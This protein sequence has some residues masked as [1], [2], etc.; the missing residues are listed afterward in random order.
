M[1]S[2]CRRYMILRPF[3]RNEV[4]LYHEWMNDSEVLGLYVE[5]DHHS[6]HELLGDF[7]SDQWQS[8][9][10][11]RWLVISQE[12]GEIMGFGHCWEFDPYETHVEFGRILLPQFRRQGLGAPLL[13][14]VIDQVFVD[15]KAHRAQSVTCCDNQTVQ[16]NWH[17]L[18]L[19]AEARLRDYMRLHGRYVDCFLLAVLRPEWIA[20]HQRWECARLIP[21][22]DL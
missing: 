8:N 19:Q 2:D 3:E 16:K 18:G 5:P 20:S 9:R 14:A 17:A 15:T 21:E 12:N 6:L 4:H 13:H 10:L 1:T 7:D 11:R 22:T